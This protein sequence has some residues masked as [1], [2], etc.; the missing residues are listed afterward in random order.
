MAK[1]IVNDVV[2]VGSSITITNGKVIID[3]KDVSSDGKTIYIYI[4]GDVTSMNADYCNS[5]KVLGNVTNLKTASSDVEIVG[6]ILNDVV[7][8]SGDINCD[9][10]NGNVET[11]SGDV[12]CNTINGF[13]ETVSGNIKTKK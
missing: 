2:Y 13:I 3:G 11:T 5:L 6:N 9:T 8:T 10:I 7:T 1:M 4:E 12:S